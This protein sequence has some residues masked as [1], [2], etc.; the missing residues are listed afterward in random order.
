MSIPN[1]APSVVAINQQREQDNSHVSQADDVSVNPSN[2]RTEYCTVVEDG[3]VVVKLV[4]I[5][6]GESQK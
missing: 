1:A 2:N 3:K 6:E 5:P 4:E